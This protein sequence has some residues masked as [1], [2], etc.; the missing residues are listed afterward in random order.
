M[1]VVYGGCIWRLYMEVVYTMQHIHIVS[2][3]HCCCCM[4]PLVTIHTLHHS[5]IQNE[6]F[7][8]GITYFFFFL[9]MICRV[10]RYSTQ[11][12]PSA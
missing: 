4:P 1:E 8:L 9:E 2:I 5:S 12:T 3:P 11:T 6:F 10:C 7:F